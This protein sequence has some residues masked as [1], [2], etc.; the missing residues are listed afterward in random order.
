LIGQG[1]FLPIKNEEIIVSFLVNAELGR[2]ALKNGLETEFILWALLRD[3]AVA[4]NHSTHFTKGLIKKIAWSNGIKFSTRH[5]TNLFSQGAPLFWKM[6]RRRV[7]LRSFAN[8]AAAMRPLCEASE[9]SRLAA[10]F[11][12]RISTTGSLLDIRSNLYWAWFAQF[13]ART[14]SRATLTD[15]FGLSGDQQRACEAQLGSKLLVK[16]NYAHIN[17][18]MYADR[19]QELPEHHFTIV[20]EREISKLQD[21]DGHIAL[22]DSTDHEFEVESVTAYQYQLP[23][24]FIARHPE[25]GASPVPFASN[26]ATNA[27]RRLC[28]GVTALPQLKRTYWANEADF[29]KFGDLESY[30][31]CYSQGKKRLFLSG[32]YF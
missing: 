20:Y 5:W 1:S 2:I 30:L 16:S 4:K 17:S 11:M 15:L 25:S 3:Y 7:F 29:I 8:V 27:I 18:D 10:V 6:N 22:R 32:N 24:T 26:R 28:R 21:L 12:V 19:P 23:N 9:M 31:K 14:I 13:E